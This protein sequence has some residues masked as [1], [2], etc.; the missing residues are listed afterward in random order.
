MQFSRAK[1]PAVIFIRSFFVSSF[2]SSLI[3]SLTQHPALINLPS[4]SLSHII[5]RLTYK[6]NR[7]LRRYTN[8]SLIIKFGQLHLRFVAQW[9]I[10]KYN[11]PFHPSN[12]VR[13]FSQSLTYSYSGSPTINQIVRLH[14][15]STNQPIITPVILY[16]QPLFDLVSKLTVSQHAFADDSQLTLQGHT[17][18][19]IRQSIETLPNALRMSS[20][21]W[22]Q[23]NFN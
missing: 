20:L 11:S 8:P 2:H 12:H 23:T 16:T 6:V 18:D 14:N 21:G 15:R 10:R 17:L 19:A 1:N 9:Q 22:P 13:L 4:H 3:H 5:H 7:A